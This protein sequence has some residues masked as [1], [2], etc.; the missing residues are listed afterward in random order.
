MAD[1]M[2][3][4]YNEKAKKIYNVCKVVSTVSAISSAV[5]SIYNLKHD[6]K[7]TTK[8]VLILDICNIVSD[9]IAFFVKIFYLKKPKFDKW[10]ATEA[11][12][13]LG[14]TKIRYNNNDLYL[15]YDFDTTKEE[16]ETFITDINNKSTKYEYEYYDIDVDFNTIRLFI[17]DKY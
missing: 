4:P 2:I 3:M 7:V 10:L 9:A 15:D 14:T 11:M 17:C 12:V 6:K 1:K 13:Q 16:I 8:D 5:K